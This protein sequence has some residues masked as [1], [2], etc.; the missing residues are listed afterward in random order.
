MAT[1]PVLAAVQLNS[2]SP[3]P[4]KE[5][6]KAA[7]ARH[8]PAG[9]ANLAVTAF[10]AADATT[11]TAAVEAAAAVEAEVLP[12]AADKGLVD[13]SRLGLPSVPGYDLIQKLG[14]GGF[15][16]VVCLAPQLTFTL[17]S[18]RSSPLPLPLPIPYP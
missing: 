12:V 10:A 5:A 2:P 6:T 11:E 18:H 13:L 3:T 8:E 4:T 17:P 9:E 15:G 1:R 14:C 7:A 16:S